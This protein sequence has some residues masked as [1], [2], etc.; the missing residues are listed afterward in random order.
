MAMKTKEGFLKTALDL[1]TGDRN[2]SH[3]DAVQQHDTAAR[4]WTI[5][6]HER[7]LV[8]DRSISAADVCNLMILL[9]ISRHISA[10]YNPDNPADMV[11]YSA[12]MGEC[13]EARLLK[14]GLGESE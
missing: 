14:E 4:L 8:R 12:I 3:G 9:K 13:E 1:V 6:L 10:E 7:G 2:R 11:G 5:Y